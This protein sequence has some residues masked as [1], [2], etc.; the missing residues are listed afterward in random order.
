MDWTEGLK[1]ISILIAAWVAV[2][3]ID[4]WRREHAG[5]RRIELAEDTL[6][7]FYEAVDVINW[8]RHPMA[9]AAETESI[10]RGKHESEGDYQARKNASVVFVRYQ[11]HQELFN[12]IHSMRYR[13]MAQ[14]GKDK[15][16]PF[17]DLRDIENEIKAA[18]RILARLW[19]R[20][21]FVTPEQ[22]ENHQKQIQNYEA[23]FWSG[24]EEEDP[25]TPKLNSVIEKIETTCQAVITGKGSLH[26]ILN[27]DMF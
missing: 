9:F 14:I 6:A 4:S 11:Q 22:W 24:I 25:I 3:G 1:Q 27:R 21:Q 13:F 20:E 15:A 2:Y 26:N 7:L 23:V 18:A 16:K 19:S 8:M 5:K 12:K 10:E 17:E